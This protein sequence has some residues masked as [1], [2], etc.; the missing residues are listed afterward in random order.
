MAN[1]LSIDWPRKYYEALE[2]V[3]G[4][5]EYTGRLA[6]FPIAEAGKT[7][8]AGNF[9]GPRDINTKQDYAYIILD[10]RRHHGDTFGYEPSVHLQF[11]V[12]VPEGNVGCLMIYDHNVAL[13]GVRA[14][15]QQIQ[16]S[17]E[18]GFHE[19][20]SLEIQAPTPVPVQERL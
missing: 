17:R 12:Q 15:A 5:P 3:A 8:K 19:A 13:S 10:D 18:G 16:Q 14:R 11:E 1:R 7:F 9:R 2:A 20:A 4:L 6:I